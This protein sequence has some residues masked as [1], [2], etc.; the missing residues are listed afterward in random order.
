[1]STDVTSLESTP[2]L[3][4]RSR[5]LFTDLRSN[6]EGQFLQSHTLP[7]HLSVDLISTREVQFLHSHT[8]PILV[9]PP[10]K[11]PL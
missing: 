2:F 8:L 5:I 4:P 1:M 10:P 3:P 11:P 6:H 9:V 7:I